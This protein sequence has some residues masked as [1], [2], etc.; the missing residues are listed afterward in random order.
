MMKCLQ[1]LRARQKSVY[2]IAVIELESITDRELERMHELGVRGIRLNFQA[3][4]KGLDV[5]RLLD[6]L[7]KAADRIC[8]LRGWM[9]QLFVPGWA[10]N[11]TMLDPS[12]IQFSH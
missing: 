5:S 6:T 2:A 12:F 3:D 1:E 8:H 11:S 10:W 4:G 9:I 7:Q